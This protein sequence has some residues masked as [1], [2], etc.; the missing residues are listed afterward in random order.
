MPRL[1]DE[2]LKTSLEETTVEGGIVR[3]DEISGCNQCVHDPVVDAVT[4][5]LV[6]GDAG[7][8]EDLFGKRSSG[9]LEAG[10]AVLDTVDDAIG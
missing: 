6:V 2:Q 3:D 10:V 5:H 8:A 1:L 4:T 9:I 7:E